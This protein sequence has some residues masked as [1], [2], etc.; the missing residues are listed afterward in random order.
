LD[1]K[2]K[3][4]ILKASKVFLH[5]P[6]LDTG[7]MAAAEAM[8]CGLP[9]VGFDLPGYKYCYPQGMRKVTIGDLEKFAQEVRNLLVNE[10][11]YQKL[12][13][14]ATE[15]SKNWDWDKKSELILDRISSLLN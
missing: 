10:G 9:V 6:I 4:E 8:A 12:K 14:E 15:F 1:G 2:E 7:G 13:K 11:A 3:F 5:T